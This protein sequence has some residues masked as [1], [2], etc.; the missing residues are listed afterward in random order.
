MNENRYLEV[1]ESFKTT[2]DVLFGPGPYELDFISVKA[3][4]GTYAT[5]DDE[6]D[7]DVVLDFDRGT[8]HADSVACLCITPDED[9]WFMDCLDAIDATQD[10]LPIEQSDQLVIWVVSQLAEAYAADIHSLFYEIGK[11]SPR[12]FG[13]ESM[14]LVLERWWRLMTIIEDFARGKW[15]E[16]DPNP[17]SKLTERALVELARQVRH[18]NDWKE[19][20]LPNFAADMQVWA[21]MLIGVKLPEL[22]EFL[23]SAS[24]IQAQQSEPQGEQQSLPVIQEVATQNVFSPRPPVAPNQYV[25]KQGLSTNAMAWIVA[26]AVGAFIAI[27]A[28]LG[29]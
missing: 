12:G 23:A 11:G 5:G 22:E 16:F 14:D 17:E 21:S 24:R 29:Y 9:S 10:Y 6:G 4:G 27:G 28:A 19:R 3:E 15:A 26:L 18:V 8:F 1:G 7:W 13:K 25:K 20:G 2:F